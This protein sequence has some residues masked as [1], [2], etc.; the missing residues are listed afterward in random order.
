M[1]TYKQ[2]EKGPWFS[3]KTTKTRLYRMLRMRVRMG[4]TT[5][6]SRS[7]MS[8]TWSVPPVIGGT[9]LEG[10]PG[11]SH[12]SNATLVI[13]SPIPFVWTGWRRP[14]GNLNTLTASWWGMQT[15]PLH[16]GIPV[17]VRGPVRKGR[18]R[19][20][21]ALRSGEENKKWKETNEAFH[22]ISCSSKQRLM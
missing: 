5:H 19:Q 10:R 4:P 11:P 9:Q 3:Y 8:R 7:R 20:Q 13:D 1:T 14:R 21:K 2:P 22:A 16:P 12:G 15:T 6:G 18:E 17:Q